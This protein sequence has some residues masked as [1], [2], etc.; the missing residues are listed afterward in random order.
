MEGMGPRYPAGPCC[1]AVLS[2]TEAGRAEP[3]A[4]PGTV[5][6]RVKR[7]APAVPTARSDARAEA[8]AERSIRA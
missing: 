8:E 6:A 5:G 7:W 3:A 1:M 2:G 4:W